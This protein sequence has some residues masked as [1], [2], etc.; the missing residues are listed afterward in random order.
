M[1]DAYG[2]NIQHTEYDSVYNA[3]SITDGNGAKTAFTYDGMGNITKKVQQLN[4]DTSATTTYSYVGG[5]LMSGVTDA[6]SGTASYEYDSEGRLT[7]I[8]NP[9]GGITS[10]TYDAN[11]NVTSEKVKGGSTHTYTYNASDLLKEKTN[12]RGQKTKY[13]YDKTG[14]IK[15]ITDEA[16]TITYGYDAAGNVLTVTEET[17]D[18]KKSTITRTYDKA[19]RVTGY[20]DASGS[21]I[22]YS[23]NELGQLTTL[24]Y[25]DGRKATYTYDRNNNIKSVTD[26]QG[27]T[28]G[29]TYNKNG[30]LTKLK[31]ADGTAET[32]EYDK[33]GQRIS[34]KDMDAEGSVIHSYSYTYNLAGS[35]TKIDREAAS[36]EAGKEPQ[37]SRGQEDSE[38]E[39][40]DASGE[41]VSSTTMEYSKD[42]RLISYN[43]EEAKYDEDGNMT[44][45]PL[46]GV[47][48]E[49]KYDCRNR[50]IKAGD[51]EYTYDA[52][53][54]RIA[55]TKNG[56]TTKYVVDS[57]CEYSQVLTATT[58]NDTVAYI[59]GDGLIAQE[60]EA[61]AQ[62]EGAEEKHK[63]SSDAENAG[64][65]TGYVTY[66]YNQV[67]STTALTNENGNVIETY[68]Y[69]P[70]GDILDGDSS[71]TM[72]L[73]NGKY[74][75]ASD[76]NGLYYMR[77]RYYNVSIK[78]FINQDVVIGHLDATSSLNRYAY[79]EGNPVSFI[80]P[81]GLN[82][83]DTGNDFADTWD[84]ELAHDIA[85]RLGYAT[86]AIAFVASIIVSPPVAFSLAVGA[87]EIIGMCEGEIYYMDAMV[88]VEKG[89]YAEAVTQ[90]I[91]ALY[92]IVFAPF[93]PISKITKMDDK[94]TKMATNLG[95]RVES[96]MKGKPSISMPQCIKDVLKEDLGP[97]L[98]D[99]LSKGVNKIINERE[100]IR[101]KVKEK[102]EEIKSW[103]GR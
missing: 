71:L 54:N 49:F 25:P 32:Y 34:Q 4:G 58:G 65:L 51:T 64:A 6:E 50:L 81:F 28:T 16:G 99:A 30:Q 103:L 41:A 68:E 35:I 69:S 56:V 40:T 5:S 47:M 8:K 93:V 91:Q 3:I 26:W 63:Q 31:R 86:Y 95:R 7:G 89:E 57:N 88:S 94:V 24:T 79:C 85:E 45:G 46:N 48:T 100:N 96:K 76:D 18:G 42:N 22:G 74:G 53:D 101:K 97:M 55:V 23:Y 21:T 73:Y 14:R 11:G 60:S 10:F 66:H 67:G 39:K 13:T 12:S 37:E 59:Y 27:R 83:K 9:N 15:T 29:Y 84:S 70:Y 52:E 75:V 90:T 20:T 1:Y 80:D 19:G 87:N 98:D 78:R 43:G 36:G 33:A 61:Y 44:C 77:A 72:F 38:T 82:R 92:N 62:S 102:I 17:K 2:N